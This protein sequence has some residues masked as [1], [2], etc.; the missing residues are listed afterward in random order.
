ML[1]V[2]EQVP[3]SRTNTISSVVWEHSQLVTFCVKKSI[4]QTIEENGKIDF[5]AL[6]ELL[7]KNIDSSIY[8]FFATRKNIEN[9]LFPFFDFLKL[10]YFSEDIH[11]PDNI[12]YII[13]NHPSIKESINSYIE[14]GNKQ[15]ISRQ[16][17][18]QYD[19]IA[20]HLFLLWMQ[21]NFNLVE[22]IWSP[23][24]DE[25]RTFLDESIWLISQAS[26]ITGS[27][28]SEVW[29]NELHRCIQIAETFNK[30]A[31]IYS[32]NIK[33]HQIALKLG[34]LVRKS[35]DNLIKKLHP[36]IANNHLIGKK[37]RNIS[38]RIQRNFAHG[39]EVNGKT[40]EEIKKQ[41]NRIKKEQQ[42]WFDNEKASDFWG[43]LAD[44]EISRIILL[45]NTT[46]A[47]F[48]G[49]EQIKIME[50]DISREEKQEQL[51]LIDNVIHIYNYG[52]K[53][54]LLTITEIIDDFVMYGIL[55]EI[56][57]ESIYYIISYWDNIQD[58]SLKKLMEFFLKKDNQ[59]D[60]IF[61]EKLMIKITASV[62]NKVNA[63]KNYDSFLSFIE[64]I[65]SFIENKDIS[66]YILSYSKIYLSLALYYI[67][68]KE[69]IFEKK[70]ETC[71][72]HYNN[73][74]NGTNNKDIVDE[75]RFYQALWKINEMRCYGREIFD[76]TSAEREDMWIF[77]FKK[78]Q[79]EYQIRA[80]STIGIELE[81]IIARI[82]MSTSHD[83]SRHEIDHL[84]GE[85]IAKIIFYNL[86]TITITESVEDCV[87]YDK[88]FRASMKSDDW[89]HKKNQWK[90]L[91]ISRKRWFQNKHIHIGKGIF[92]T[93]TYLSI[94]EKIFTAIF[95]QHQKLIKERFENLIMIH[96]HNRLLLEQKEA[97]MIDPKTGVFNET[98]LEMDLLLDKWEKDIVLIDISGYDE[99]VM[100]LK[101][102]QE[103]GEIMKEI[104]IYLQEVSGALIY[105]Y[106]EMTFCL[107]YEL[108]N[109]P[110]SEKYL[111]NLV[112]KFLEYFR[113]KYDGKN[114]FHVWIAIRPK[115]H[116]L[117][118]AKI[119]LER[120]KREEWRK[121]IWL[122]EKQQ[123]EYIY[124]FQAG[125]EKESEEISH[126]RAILNSALSIDN[127]KTK[128]TPFYQRIY[129]PKKPYRKKY[130]ALV[131]ISHLRE[132]GSTEIITPEKFLPIA[133]KDKKISE[134]TR[135]M[136][137]EIL[138]HMSTRD[139]IEVSINLDQEDWQSDENI[140]LLVSLC[141]SFK[142]KHW[143]I[144]VEILETFHFT[145]QK[146]KDQVWKLKD[147][148]FHISIDDYGTEQGNM[149]KILEARPSNV[150]IDGSII[151]KLSDPLE[152]M[153][154]TAAI[155]GIIFQA[156]QKNGINFSTTAE[157]VES[158]E[159]FDL[160]WSLGVN[161]FQWY[162]FSRPLP[163]NE[164]DTPLTN[165]I[166]KWSWTINTMKKIMGK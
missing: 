151:K 2:G 39:I 114:R 37:L 133:Q 97:L 89:F 4:E 68:Y 101:G 149:N 63:L 57:V 3:L 34:T 132:D 43:N 125:D 20:F 107:V 143:R 129:D 155:R 158:K 6:I 146:E 111:Y 44:E 124:V 95:Q 159:I 148:W 25:T 127:E 144:S 110:E 82:M 73:L 72:L 145:T 31:L 120:A 69:G 51:R 150:K 74:T 61:Y 60:N 50:G 64:N 65:F 79:E 137:H 100:T 105:R 154:A 59:I 38:G 1:Q 142:I 53:K 10:T 70:A 113:L 16:H 112:K 27:D 130:E 75:K 123:W 108:M 28:I 17:I 55:N 88:S 165:T 49:M 131:R 29:I 83:N 121:T 128:I 109:Y 118:Y 85:R 77:M 115:I 47:D 161:F 7:E 58:E 15:I 136:I 96:Y 81:A 45:G 106:N 56:Q 24:L 26:D 14:Q 21:E 48:R 54:N 86:C 99:M 66:Q 23:S 157:Y 164:I 41:I 32:V 116:H 98:K 139:D 162:Y 153:Y 103:W 12:K 87:I 152:V 52:V 42:E 9:I 46:I 76:N 80:I 92:I 126:Y 117:T 119:A 163:F 33:E 40:R 122:E 22:D 135:I 71:F 134:V 90:H 8:D 141:D 147:L 30:L 36:D 11:I 104:V 13:R 18:E 35:I 138:F 62:I 160:L 67:S 156:K 5:V 140:S 166:V 19:T 94:S 102:K 84:F 93:F 91:Y 78:I